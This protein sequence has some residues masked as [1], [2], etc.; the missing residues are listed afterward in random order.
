M[1]LSG[2]I[3]AFLAQGLSLVDAA[4]LGVYVGT[5][6]AR[7]LEMELGTLGLVAGDLPAQSQSSWPRWSG[8]D[9]DL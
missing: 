8:N 3:G 2:M 7:R 9:I 4:N 6:A 5:H 1:S